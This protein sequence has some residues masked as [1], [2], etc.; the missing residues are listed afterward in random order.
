MNIKAT[1]K[2]Q[3]FK[4]IKRRKCIQ[5]G[6][7]CK[8]GDCVFRTEKKLLIPLNIDAVCVQD[9]VLVEMLSTDRWTHLIPKL[10]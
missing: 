6:K 2:T 7:M 10:V 4:A 8:Y 3:M 9:Q 1:C 5:N